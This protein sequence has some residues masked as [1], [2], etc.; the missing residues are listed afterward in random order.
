MKNK[1]LYA[2]LTVLMIGATSV[3]MADG[4][5]DGHRSPSEHGKKMFE[6]MD[7][8]KDGIVTREEHNTF[9]NARFD[10]MDADKN[11]KVTKEEAEKHREMRKEKHKEKRAERKN[12]R[13]E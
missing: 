6:E 4:K 5:R 7:A 13:D 12:K 10:E 8:N 11:G 2:A 9:T 1:V 3:A